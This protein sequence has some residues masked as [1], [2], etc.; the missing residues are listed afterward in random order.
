MPDTNLADYMEKV[1]RDV[2]KLLGGND[3]AKIW[4]I[5]AGVPELVFQLISANNQDPIRK[6]IRLQLPHEMP[7]YKYKMLKNAPQWS[8]VE[9]DR[10][11]F[12]ECVEIIYVPHQQVGRNTW[13]YKFERI[14]G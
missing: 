7:E 8:R 13:I 4:E 1:L 10:A 5:L 12:P 3:D 9:T 11:K 2:W 14:I 6:Y